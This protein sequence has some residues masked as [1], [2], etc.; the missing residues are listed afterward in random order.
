MKVRPL[1]TLQRV[2][3]LAQLGRI[4]SAPWVPRARICSSSPSDSCT[5]AIQL[6]SCHSVESVTTVLL[7]QAQ[8]FSQFRGGDRVLKSIKNTLSILNTLSDT[9]TLG[10][11]LAWYARRH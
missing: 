11:P 2:L 5:L 6:Q 1:S 4:L 8:T 9:I 7:D 10:K 3:P